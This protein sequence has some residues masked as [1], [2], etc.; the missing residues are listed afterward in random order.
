MT[1][2]MLAAKFDRVNCVEKLI[3][4]KAQLLLIVYALFYL[5]KSKNQ[6]DPSF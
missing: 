4:L 5:K 1:P 3:E 2:L 6:N